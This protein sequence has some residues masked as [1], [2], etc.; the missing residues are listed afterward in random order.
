MG[1]LEK[2]TFTLKYGY[3]V[4][5]KMSGLEKGTYTL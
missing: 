1:G 4:I 2:G 5:I 3:W